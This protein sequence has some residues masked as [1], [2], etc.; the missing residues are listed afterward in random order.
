MASATFYQPQNMFSPVIWYGDVVG[1][2]SAHI[3]ISAGNRSGT[4][5]GSFTFN[6]DGLAGGTVTGYDHFAN[7]ALDYSYRDGNL[8]ALTVEYYLDR[9]NALGLQQ[10]VLS[11]ADTIRGSAGNDQIQAWAGNDAIFGAAGND[12]IRGGAGD[13]LLDGG[14]GTDIAIFSGYRANYSITVTASGFTVRDNFGSDGTD[15]LVSVERL[16]FANARVAL[17]IA[18]NPN[19]GFDLVGTAN[20]GQVY[21]LYKAAFNREPDRGGLAYWVSQGDAGIPLVAIAG[22]FTGSAEFRGSYDTLSDAQFIDRLYQ[23]VLGRSGDT[24]G[25][26]YWQGQLAS[27]AQT[28]EQVLVGFAESV[29]NQAAVIGV[30]QQGIDY[31]A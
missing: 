12:Q 17:D 21:R 5:Y 24:A 11:G 26:S 8:N 16:Q 4:Y 27:H 19:A 15:F 29:E 14:S 18:S 28:R 2:S 9:G 7:G 31:A 30:I 22:G 3:T 1:Y 6:S 23:N 10:Y 13:D 25:L 20:A